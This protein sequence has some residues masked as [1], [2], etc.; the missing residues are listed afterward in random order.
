MNGDFLGLSNCFTTKKSFCPS[1][2]S[3]A[4][5]Q[6]AIIDKPIPAL[7]AARK[8]KSARIRL[9]ISLI[10][11]VLSQCFQKRRDRSFS[12]SARIRLLIFLMEKELS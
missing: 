2:F 5:L 8:P 4:F 11:K 3:P 1:V 7:F 6:T 10:G 12:K 9:L